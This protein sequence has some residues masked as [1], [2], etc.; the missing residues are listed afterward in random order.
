MITSLRVA[1]MTC[2][3]CVKHVGEAL[4]AIPGVQA[5]DVDLTAGRAKVAHDVTVEVA[6]L[7]AAVDEAGYEAGPLTDVA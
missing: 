5:V 3:G 1:G 7:L 6:A 2:N 4:R